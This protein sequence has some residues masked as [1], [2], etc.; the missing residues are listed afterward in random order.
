MPTSRTSSRF[1]PWLRAHQPATLP[2]VEGAFTSVRASLQRG[3]PLARDEMARLLAL[4]DRAAGAQVTTPT[5]VSVFWF[6][7]LVIVREGFEAAVIIAALLAVLKKRGQLVR[8]RYVHAGWVAALAVGAIVFAVGRTVLAGAMNETLEGVLAIAAT[9]ML[10]HAALWL[11]ARKTTRKTMGEL[12][13]RTHGALDRGALALF[14][15]A[16]FAMFRETFETTVFLEALSIDAPWAVVWGGIVGASLLFGLVLA[17]G[18]LGLR[19]PMQ[20]LFKAST[21]VL[22][23][24]AVVLVGQGVHSFDEV[25]LVGSRPVPFVSVPFLGMY[26]DL[27]SLLAQLVVAAAPLVWLALHRGSSAAPTNGAAVAGE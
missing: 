10:L 9:A 21:V 23:A 19:L 7:L 11:N 15:I 2:V 8:A 17:V 27:V 12:R 3:D 25:G 18:R 6:A 5:K 1:E 26:P 4:L 24:T 13:Q 20:A 16:F 22:V 14:G